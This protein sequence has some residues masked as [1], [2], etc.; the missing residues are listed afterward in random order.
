VVAAVVSEG[1]FERA[2]AEGL[3]EQLM[4]ETDAENRD[5]AQ[6]LL[7]HPNLFAERRGVPGPLDRNTPSGFKERISSAL[8]AA[9]TTLRRN[10][11]A[12]WCTIVVLMP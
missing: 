2:T 11:F 5:S 12:S 8:V 4:T 10:R 6:Q 7:E 3:G 1:E 9:G